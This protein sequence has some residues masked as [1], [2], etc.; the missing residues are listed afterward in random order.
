MNSFSLLLPFIRPVFAP[1]RLAS[2]NLHSVRL[3]I[4][5]RNSRYSLLFQLTSS[6]SVKFHFMLRIVFRV[7][8]WHFSTF[9]VSSSLYFVVVVGVYCEQHSS[10]RFHW[11]HL[12]IQLVSGECESYEEKRQ[13]KIEEERG[14]SS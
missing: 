3:N 2:H 10:Y 9:I 8:S 14:R 7:S 5:C 13:Q 11:F 1:F 6:Q 4:S 12:L